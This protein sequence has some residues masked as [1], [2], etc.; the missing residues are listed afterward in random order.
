MPHQAPQSHSSLLPLVPA[1]HTC[2]FPPNR[3]YKNLI[4]EA[5]VC[6]NVCPH[7]LAHKCS[8][9]SHCCGPRPLA[10]PTPSILDPHWDSL[11]SDTLWLSWVT[12]ILQ[13]WICRTSPFTHFSSSLMKQMLGCTNSEPWIWALVVAELVSL[14]GLGGG[15]ASSP[16]W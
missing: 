8:L 5:V 14:W 16:P 1:L 11:L 3:F 12:E 10:S 4:V 7:F 9:Q 2:N 15:G 6:H 13:P